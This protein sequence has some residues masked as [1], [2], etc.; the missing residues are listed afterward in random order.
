MK[1]QV[2]MKWVMSKWKPRL[3][4]Q[5]HVLAGVLFLATLVFSAPLYG[6]DA[7][8]FFRK[9]LGYMQEGKYDLAIKSFHEA[10]EISPEIPELLNYLGIAYLHVAGK[11]EDSIYYLKRAVEIKPQYAEAYLNLGSAYASLGDNPLLALEYFEK[12]IELAPKNAGRAYAGS[13]WI[14][15]TA[16]NDGRKAA[17]FFEKSAE[18]FP[19]DPQTLYGLG[20]TNAILGKKA[21][22]LK[23]LSRLRAMNQHTLAGAIENELKGDEEKPFAMEQTEG[24]VW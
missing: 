3:S 2:S 1:R 7:Q 14:Y 21:A 9:G 18:F 19:D 24:D 5:A 17:E 13:A 22:A 4:R 11:E 16:L 20:L 6:E 12:A 8:Q 10:V 15:L 23:P